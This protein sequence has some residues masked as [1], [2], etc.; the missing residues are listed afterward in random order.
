MAD[1]KIRFIGCQ[2]LLIGMNRVY[3]AYTST[4]LLKDAV[5]VLRRFLKDTVLLG[6]A[7]L[8]L[9]QL[10]KLFRAAAGTKH[11]GSLFMQATMF[12]GKDRLCRLT[13]M[14]VYN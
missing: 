3:R 13:C 8:T 6:L 14:N 12:V 2:S 5:V 11:G 1:G 9:R 10:L 4:I 7:L